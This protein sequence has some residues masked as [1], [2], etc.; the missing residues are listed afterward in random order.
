MGSEGAPV[1]A[2]MTERG[3]VGGGGS[4][5]FVMGMES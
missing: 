5:V 3:E 1:Y 2:R 4:S